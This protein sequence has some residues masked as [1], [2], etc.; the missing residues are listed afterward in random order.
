MDLIAL[1]IGV[2][3]AGADQDAAE[4][5]GS[6]G[7]V[8]SAGGRRTAEVGWNAHAAEVEG[9]AAAVR[10]RL[11]HD[12]GHH[13]AGSLRVGG[14]Q[15]IGQGRLALARE[16]TLSLG[17]AATDGIDRQQDRGAGRARGGIECLGAILK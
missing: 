3:R 17:G 14:A 9:R 5:A 11:G 8:G 4:Q 1:G 2:G 16:K 10:G 7:G 15:A 12:G 13:P 6:G